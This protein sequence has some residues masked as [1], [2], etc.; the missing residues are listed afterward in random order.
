MLKSLCQASLISAACLLS[1]C[2]TTA[3]NSQQQ[4]NLNL[5]QNKTWILTHIGN[6]EYNAN[7]SQRNIPSLQ[8][9]AATQRI[10][11]ADGCNRIMGAYTVHADKLSLGQLAGS[12][13]LCMD[14]MTLAN[15]YNEAL[16]KVVGYQVYNKTLRLLDQHGNPLLQ[17]KS[18]IQP[19]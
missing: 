10:S 4:H 2:S 15:Q 8:F 6:T 11:G 1:A 9:D 16:S 7:P 14:Q 17:F 5:L 13:M 12:Q 19:R 18:A 3:T